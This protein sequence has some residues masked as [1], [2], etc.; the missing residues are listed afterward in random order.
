MSLE[1]G[2]ARKWLLLSFQK[3]PAPPQPEISPGR[4]YQA[5]YLE[6]GKAIHLHCCQAL[7]G[8]G[9]LTAA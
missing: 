7:S 6:S 8:W 9:V 3:E 4:L 2:K 1:A 5:S